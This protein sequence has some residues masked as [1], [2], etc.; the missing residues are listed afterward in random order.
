MRLRESLIN[1]VNFW[2]EGVGIGKQFRRKESTPSNGRFV[3][4]FEFY[5]QRLRINTFSFYLVNT[6]YGIVVDIS[7]TRKEL[8]ITWNYCCGHLRKG[9]TQGA[10]GIKEATLDGHSPCLRH[11]PV[12]C[13]CRQW[14]TLVLLL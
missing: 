5:F 9:N 8:E 10:I 13:N 14:M 2:K 1:M 4:K 11:A 12:K 3:S 6:Y 7:Y